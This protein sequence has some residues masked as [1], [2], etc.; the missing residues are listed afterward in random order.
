[1]SNVTQKKSFTE[2]L[3][4]PQMKKRIEEVLGNRKNQFVGS[5]LSLYN[6][7]KNLQN[8]EPSSLFN[9]CLTASSL[10]LPINNNLGLAYIIP[11]KEKQAD[12]TWI[13]VAQ[14]QIGYK[15]FKQLAL[16]TGQFKTINA[17]EVR[18]G[19]LISFD[20]L[21]GEL[22]FN[23]EQDIEKR[24]QL[25]VVGYVS[26]FELTNGF[27]NTLFMDLNKILNHAKKFSKT[28]KNGYGIWK[29]EQDAMALKTVLK[30]N[31]SKNA[32]L[33]ID[34]QKAII[35]DQAVVVENGFNYIDNKQVNLLENN[36]IEEDKRTLSSLESVLDLQNFKALK[37]SVPVEVYNR[38][39][40]KFLE[41]EQELLTN[42]K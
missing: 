24:Q 36:T 3:E 4:H 25:E 39:E 34:L 18:K 37:D 40:A 31:L 10:D 38:L 17:T 9:A 20:Y 32:P 12:N 22:S 8:C 19:E 6:T 28:F 29:D 2:L 23:W 15:G 5:V 11:Y 42:Q 30:L 41:K 7:N 33:S 16:R 27:K 35:S 1:M 26:Y 14:F 13:E 21:T